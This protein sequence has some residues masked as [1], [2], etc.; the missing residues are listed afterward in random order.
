MMNLYATSVCVLIQNLVKC[1]MIQFYLVLL[2]VHVKI[3]QGIIFLCFCKVLVE[4][5]HSD[6]FMKTDILL[7]FYN[8]FKVVFDF[9]QLTLYR[10]KC[11][12][13]Y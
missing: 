3:M 12:S 7:F 2:C 1:K 9:Q 8:H 11:I 10:L 13:R 6:Y 5:L 4:L